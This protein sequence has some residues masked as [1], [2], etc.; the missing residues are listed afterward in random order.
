V[1]ASHVTHLEIEKR[2]LTL[3]LL[4]RFAKVLKLKYEKL[5]MLAHPDAKFLLGSRQRNRFTGLGLV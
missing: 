3:G 1:K 4:N 2:K 5:L